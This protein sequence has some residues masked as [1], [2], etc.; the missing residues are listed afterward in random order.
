MAVSLHSQ[1]SWRYAYPPLQAGVLCRRYKRF[2]AEIELSSGDRIVAH[3]PN[4]GPM[5]GIC[6]VGAPVQVSYHPD[7]RRKLAYTWE[8]IFVDG[9]WVGVN[10]GLP[11][12]V[13]A[14]ALAAG[15]LPELAG[16]AN[17]Q[18]EVPYGQERSRIDFFLT[19]HPQQPPAYVEVKNT[20]WARSGLALFPD[21]VTTRGQKHLRELQWLR[22]TQ[23]QA[24]VCMVYFINRGDCDRFA[25]GDS[26]D[27]TYGEL[28]RTAVAMGVEV[29]PYRFAISPAGIDFLGTAKLTLCNR[30]IT[31]AK[32]LE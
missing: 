18:R 4:T 1:D 7:P 17:H 26:A 12:K 23:P 30:S 19:G 6:E 3:C 27:P 21:T 8:M 32:V 22:Q 13:I 5:T 10:T 2:F 16:Y 31:T 15:K 24:R 29:L 28:L 11:N 25:P 20:T 14:S 9:T